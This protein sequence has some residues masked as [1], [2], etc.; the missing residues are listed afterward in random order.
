M[1]TFLCRMCIG[2][3][4]IIG[5]LS[6]GNISQDVLNFRISEVLEGNIS[7]ADRYRAPSFNLWH[8]ACYWAG[9]QLLFAYPENRVE[10]WL[11]ILF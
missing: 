2:M 5:E 8:I 9:I 1:E 10:I 11:V 4:F 3:S 6:D 7:L